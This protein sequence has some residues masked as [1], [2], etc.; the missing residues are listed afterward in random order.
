[1]SGSIDFREH[2]KRQLSFLQRSAAAYDSGH[3]DEA[4]RIATAIRV[5]IHNTR[6]SVSLLHHLN[7]DLIPLLSTTEPASARAVFY[8]GMNFIQVTGPTNEI[9][10]RPALDKSLTHRLISAQEW[11]TE[12]IYVLNQT[13]L[14]RKNIVLSAANK[15]GGAHVDSSLDKDYA[16][17]KRGI[18]ALHGN[19]DAETDVTK[20]Q[21]VFLRQMAFEIL[22]SPALDDLAKYGT[23]SAA[24]NATS[25]PTPMWV[26]P[27]VPE[28]DLEQMTYAE[29]ERLRSIVPEPQFR[30]LDNLYYSSIGSAANPLGNYQTAQQSGYPW[31]LRRWLRPLI[32]EN[33]IVKSQRN[34]NLYELT[35]RGR[36]FV[37][38]IIEI[39]H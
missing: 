20:P 24:N 13:R 5:L 6:T 18:W 25:T 34:N 35:G 10:V 19:L 33:L 36:A 8:D 1:M 39:G 17:F 2:L 23:V 30:L 31:S 37:A 27:P 22:N 26:P 9:T 4:Y 3:I 7:C 12:E 28:A 32:T 38:R 11:W 21:F 14:A 16:E 29:V 15:D